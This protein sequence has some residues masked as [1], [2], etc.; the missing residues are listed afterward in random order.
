MAEEKKKKS[1]IDIPPKSPWRRI[2]P[3]VIVFALVAVVLPEWVSHYWVN[4]ISS[5]VCLTMTAATVALLYG[6]LGMVSLAQFALAG[7]GGWVCLRFL[8]GFDIPFEI[9]VLLGGLIAGVFGLLLGL[10]ALRMRGLYLALLTLLVAA[11]FQVIV[12]VISFPDGGP[13]FTGKVETGA[14]VLI[15]RPWLA[16]SDAAYFRYLM[17][18]LILVMGFLEWQRASKSGRAWALIRKSEA[19]ATAAGV[20]VVGYKARAFFMGGVAAGLAGGLLA[21]L[22]GQLEY[23][24][25]HVSQSILLFALV[26]VGGAYNWLGA[27]AAGLLIRALPALLNGH[28]V[29]GNLAN[30]FFGFATLVSLIQGRK[31]IVGQLA[32]FFKFVRMSR[33]VEGTI[34][35]FAIAGLFGLVY[36][37]LDKTSFGGAFFTALVALLFRVAIPGVAWLL[38]GFF[39]K[40]IQDRAED[41]EAYLSLRLAQLMAKIGLI[42]DHRLIKRG[43]NWWFNGFFIAWVV[44]GVF[45]VEFAYGLALVWGAMSLKIISEKLLYPAVLP[46]RNAI[47]KKFPKP[48]AAYR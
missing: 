11:A 29:D 15:G 18:W 44:W 3:M 35:W 17:V 26:V 4:S 30:V 7:V 31:G 23:S 16:Q 12:N 45:E 39:G 37:Y 41:V 8:H 28:G 22:N 40:P 36:M 10:P 24:G 27:V 1:N 9:G 46:L 47:D 43:L 25:F 14:R 13:G 21:G 33:I 48:L 5:V 34:I 32:D 2:M 42:P 20:S 6:Q 38:L 19:A